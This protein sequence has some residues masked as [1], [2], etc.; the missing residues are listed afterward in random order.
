[1]M[2]ITLTCI[3]FPS[4]PFGLACK[5]KISFSLSGSSF[6]ISYLRYSVVIGIY[7]KDSNS[8]SY[9]GGQNLNIHCNMLSSERDVGVI[10]SA[11]GIS[12]QDIQVGGSRRRYFRTRDNSIRIINRYD[13]TYIN[14]VL[15][16]KSS[17][18]NVYENL[19]IAAIGC[20]REN[21]TAA[22]AFK[23]DIDFTCKFK[24]RVTHFN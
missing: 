17:R 10:W 22:N 1:M 21:T 18:Y 12:R 3:L 14:S 20:R 16:F 23:I 24:D 15:L 11:P 2:P 8:S 7:R 5:S 13:N 4:F 6:L 19:A 9:C